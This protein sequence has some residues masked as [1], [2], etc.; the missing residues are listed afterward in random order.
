[1]VE[2]RF[3]EIKAGLEFDKDDQDTLDFVTA[4]SN[5]RMWNYSIPLQTSFKIKEIAGNIVPAVSSTNGIVAGFETSEAVK[6]F[7]QS[8]NSLMA[9]SYS[10]NESSRKCNSLELTKDP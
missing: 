1:M 3:E 8:Y 5:L 2:Q 4:A 6:I 10:A 7:N 9:I